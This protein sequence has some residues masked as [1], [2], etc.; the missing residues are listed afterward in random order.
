[1]H[2]TWLLTWALLYLALP[3]HALA[4][5][6]TGESSVVLQQSKEKVVKGQVT[7]DSGPVIGATVKIKGTAV[8]AITDFD[9]N[10][11]FKA[12][13]GQTIE[14][15][16]IGYD[17][18][19]IVYKGESLLK[20]RIKESES[21]SLEEVQVIAYG[22]QKK[23]TVT[24]TLTSIG[25]DEIMKSPVGNMAN[26][27]SGKV[28][29][30]SSV[31]ASG[32]PGSDGATLFVRGV[33]S[34]TTGLSSP[35]CLVDGVERSFTQID[36]N[37]VEDIIVL[38]DASATDVFGVRGANGVILVTTKRGT[39]GKAKISFSTSASVQLPTN[40]PEFANSYEC[41][42]AYNAAQLR[43]GVAEDKLMFSPEVIEKFRTGSNPVLYPSVSW[44][45]LLIRMLL[46]SHSTILAYQEDLT[47]CV[48]SHHLVY[49]LR[50]VC[51]K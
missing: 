31:Q 33:G 41:A 49:L 11:S 14:V 27:L 16:Y 34:L 40:I 12:Q 9:G 10:F 8:G 44:T 38:K 42:N 47:V 5:N 21:Q 3:K 17:T 6:L 43:D 18:K 22:A 37:E 45:D 19:A 48:I 13:P 29:G 35:L 51:S 50:V 2:K 28:P 20:I 25:S 30:L 24:G 36:P 1:M 4:S 7:D 32:Q 39:K 26:A 46:C 15:S 23:V